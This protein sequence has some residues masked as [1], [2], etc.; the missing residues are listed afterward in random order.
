MDC[1]MATYLPTYMLHM[2]CRLLRFAIAVAVLPSCRHLPWDGWAGLIQRLTVAVDLRQLQL[3][4]VC[5]ECC[6]S[7]SLTASTMPKSISTA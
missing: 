6:L 5:H 7:S 2:I 3:S 4:L 1:K